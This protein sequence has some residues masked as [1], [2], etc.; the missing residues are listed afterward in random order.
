[1]IRQILLVAI[2]IAALAVISGTASANSLCMYP[3]EEKAD[4]VRF[5]QTHLMVAALQCRYNNSSKLPELYNDF[6]K[7]HDAHLKNSEQPLRAFLKRQGEQ[8]LDTYMVMIANR[9]SLKS[10]S[11]TEFCDRTQAV[12]ELS[13]QA[14][15]PEALVDLM[16][17][18]YARP[19]GRCLNEPV[20]LRY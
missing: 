4:K 13:H 10:V 6:V 12:A 2:T 1:M 18:R 5:V 20:S 19:A 7:G 14:S 16:P 17:V 9:V 3:V 15:S 8:T 11:T